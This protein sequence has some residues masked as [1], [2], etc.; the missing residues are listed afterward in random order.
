MNG[1]CFH[2]QGLLS[3]GGPTRTIQSHGARVMHERCY[4]EWFAEQHPVICPQCK[5]AGKL[6]T[7]TQKKEEC[8]HGGDPKYG[9]FASFAG[10]E[11]CPDLKSYEVPTAWKGCDLCSGTGRLRYEPTPITET[12]IVGWKK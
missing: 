2:C 5:G 10:C 3:K 7:H 1:N 8:C 6:V 11:Y 9:G 4:V 12:K